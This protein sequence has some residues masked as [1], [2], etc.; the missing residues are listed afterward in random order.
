MAQVVTGKAQV[1]YQEKNFLRKGGQVLEWAAQGGGGVT[2]P[3]GVRETFRCCTEGG[4][5]V[6]KWW[7]QVDGCTG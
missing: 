7:W 4:G 2:V 3:G 1:G 6:E 5:L